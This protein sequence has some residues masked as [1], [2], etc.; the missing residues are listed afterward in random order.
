MNDGVWQ[1][2]A[3]ARG[4]YGLKRSACEHSSQGPS[5][6]AGGGL[7]R[8]QGMVHE[9]GGAVSGRLKA[10][11]GFSIDNLRSLVGVAFVIGVAWALSDNRTK[12]PWRIVAVAL[13]LEI[14]LAVSMFALPPLRALLAWPASVRQRAGV[15]SSGVPHRAHTQA[16][17]RSGA[18]IRSSTS[19]GIF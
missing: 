11:M 8:R 18:G 4:V 14:V 5:A 2:T 6:N 9:L 10:G 19:A 17:L 16:L 15:A 12:F 13:G 7:L 3:Q 1:P